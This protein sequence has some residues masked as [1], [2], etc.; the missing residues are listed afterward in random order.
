MLARGL[1]IAGLAIGI[2]HLWFAAQALFV[3]GEDEPVG[4]W[5]SV[6]VGPGSTLAA[7]ALATRRPSLAGGWLLLAGVVALAVFSAGTSVDR[8]MVQA[9]LLRITLP[10]V[11]LGILLLVLPS[12]SRKRASRE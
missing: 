7:V 3:F 9:F 5:V 4:S 6:L 11:V 8:A 10:M 2:W 1:L 12:V